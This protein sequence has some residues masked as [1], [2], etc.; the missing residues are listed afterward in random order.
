M[1]EK[2]LDYNSKNQLRLNISV[3][4]WNLF[5][6]VFINKSVFTYLSVLH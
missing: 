3:Q 1:L 5:G 6:Y 4:V 2:P